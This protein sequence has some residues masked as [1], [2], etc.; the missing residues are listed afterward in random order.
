MMEMISSIIMI[1]G[2]LAVEYYLV[3]WRL[4]QDERATYNMV[5][6]FPLRLIA[7]NASVAKAIKKVTSK[8]D[9]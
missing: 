7:A 9:V 8:I 1:A 4:K 6:F 3:V 2:I 5:E